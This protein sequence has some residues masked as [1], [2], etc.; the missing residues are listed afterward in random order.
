MSK[1]AVMYGIAEF[2]DY[3]NVTVV[4]RNDWENLEAW[5]RSLPPEIRSSVPEMYTLPVDIWEEPLI[6][7]EAS[8]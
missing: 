4:R 6:S 2:S 5:V 3:Q 1:I 7:S 8:E